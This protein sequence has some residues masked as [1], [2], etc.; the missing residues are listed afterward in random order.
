MCSGRKPAIRAC[1]GGRERRD[2]ELPDEDPERAD[3]GGGTCHAARAD[4]PHGSDPG[5]EARAGL[6]LAGRTE[7]PG[8][9]RGHGRL[10]PVAVLISPT[11]LRG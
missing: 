5:A 7:A 9:A 1:P 6:G 2:R 3:Q 11:P 10:L 8:A 4:A